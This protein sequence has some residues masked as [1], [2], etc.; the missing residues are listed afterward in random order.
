[1]NATVYPQL[2]VMLVDDEPQALNSFENV[3]RSARINHFLRC[4]DSR[5]VLPLLQQQPPELILLDLRMPHISGEELLSTLRQEHPELPVIIITA[6]DDVETAVACMKSGAFDYL[7]KPVETSRLISA[8]LRAIQLCELRR[9]NSLLKDRVLSDRLKHP[10]CFA[11]IVT[12]S[13][14]MHSVFR[15]IEAVSV[16]PHPVVITGETGVGKEM[17]AG[18]V[19]RLSARPGNYVAV[20]IAGMDEKMVYDTLFG[21]K[22]GAYT[23]ADKPR[24]GLVEQA[25]G[26]TLFLDEI[27]D[28]G[29]DVQVTLLRLLQEGEYFP[30]GSDIPKRSDARI[31]A[32]TNR[33]LNDLRESGRFRKDFYYRLCSHHVIV[34]PL[35]DR[36][37]DLPLLVDHFLE[38]AASALNKKKPTPPE[39]LVVLLSSYHFPGNI[40]ELEAMTLDAVSCHKSGKLSLDVFRKHIGQ[41]LPGNSPDSRSSD[42]CPQPLLRFTDPLPTLKQAEQLLIDEAMKRS[43][44]NQAIAAMHLGITRQALNRRL[45]KIRR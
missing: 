24:S 31:I 10:E 37:E 17:I 26:G 1:M 8:T 28:L 5:E 2:P 14:A 6:A 18:A 33:D 12:C 21:H 34:P 22:K 30:L 38:K 19:H 9:E 16:S 15:Y 42:F 7:V 13:S 43:E 3:L 27:G 41:S 4:Q 20:N 44:G 25:S 11:E 40:R 23:S 29:I 39:E 35:R 32:A 36:R 45:R